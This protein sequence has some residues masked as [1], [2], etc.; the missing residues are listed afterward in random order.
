MTER[1][2]I[3][4]V[5]QPAQDERLDIPV[6]WMRLPAVPPAAAMPT[7]GSALHASV[8]TAETCAYMGKP[9]TTQ[10]AFC[11]FM[12]C[13][14]AEGAKVWRAALLSCMARP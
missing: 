1:S 14:R 9:F 8:V 5:M 6:A 10:M 4:T 2:G 7:S 11:R 3:S 13:G 12:W